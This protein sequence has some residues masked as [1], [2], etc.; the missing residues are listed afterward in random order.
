MIIDPKKTAVLSL[1]IQEGILGFVPSAQ[2]AFPNAA[3]V[4]ESSR[5]GGFLLIHV[6]I[7][8]NLDILK[9]AQATRVFR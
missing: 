6:G 9:S 8:L 4:V 1:D 3:R 7:G 2:A 5:K